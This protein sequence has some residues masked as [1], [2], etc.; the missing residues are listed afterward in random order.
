MDKMRALERADLFAGLP[1]EQLKNLARM[2]V[3]KTYDK[4]A[5]VFE[6]GRP[7][8][9]FFII[10]SGRVRIYKSSLS[11][12][13]QILHLFGPGEAIAEVAMF[14]GSAYP[15]AAQAMEPSELLFIPRKGFEDQLKAD[16]ELA[17][18]ML[19]LLSKRLRFF[20]HKI[21]ELSLKEVPARLAAHLVLLR[22]S[23]DSDEFRLDMPKGWIASYLGTIQETL[24]RALK[25]MSDEGL[26]AI[27]GSQVTILD[28]AGLEELAGMSR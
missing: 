11:G 16:P 22:E 14:H 23:R 18:K 4:G 27:K 13:E 9:G 15:A 8:L 12:K 19:G 2:A 21:E 6:A 17:M 10:V 25:K 1:E 26:I 28:Q 3:A 7:A 5:E 20:V 24:S